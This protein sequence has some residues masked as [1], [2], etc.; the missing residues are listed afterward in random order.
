MELNHALLCV[1]CEWLYAHHSSCPRCGSQ[2]AFPLA[3]A[4]DRRTQAVVAA[5]ALPINGHRSKLVPV[6]AA[7]MHLEKDADKP[8][9]AYRLTA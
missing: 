7:V 3:R 2:V 9:P 8:A 1:D 6:G 5:S 4:L